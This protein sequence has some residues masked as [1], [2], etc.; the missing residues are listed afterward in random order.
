MKTRLRYLPISDA[1]EGMILGAPV[2]LSAN[3]VS[4]FT[5]A[6]GHELTESNINQMA[7]R[8]AEFV[9]IEE[10]DERSEAEREAEW[11]IEEMRLNH[12]FRAAD[13]T[14][15]SMARLHAAIFAYRRK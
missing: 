6:T 13:L 2:V 15:P 10:P 5:L 1:R 12:I 9:C 8:N 7:V 14:L 3:G 4:N 11:A